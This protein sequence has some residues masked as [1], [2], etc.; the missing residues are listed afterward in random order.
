M[1]ERQ[2]RQK[3]DELLAA[4]ENELAE[5]KQATNN[6]PL[7]NIG[8][9]FSAL[10]NEANL[11]EKEEAWLIFGVRDDPLSVVG[12]NYLRNREEIKALKQQ[13]NSDTSPNMTF[14]DI[15]ELNNH[16]NGRVVMMQIPPAPKG[17]PIAWKGY[18]HAR[19]GESLVPLSTNKSDQIRNQTISTDWSAQIVEDAT[20]DNLDETACLIARDA[21]I[22]KHENRVQ[23]EEVKNW[24]LEELLDRMRIT[25]SGRITRTALLLLG[26]PEAAYKLSPH[27]AEI[28]WNLQQKERDYQHFS[29]PFLLATTD[30]YNKIRNTKIRL[31]SENE[32]IVQEVSKYDQS[33]VLEALHNCIAHQDYTQD[34]RIIVTEYTSKL[35]FENQ[36]NF[37]E[38]N[39]GKLCG[40]NKNSKQIPQNIPCA[41]HDR[42]KY[43]R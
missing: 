22:R 40:G 30:I 35:T 13:I 29:P 7:D 10:A 14:R 9:Y 5:F 43:D 2:L 1:D 37:F 20:L 17:M 27:P 36:G 33:V 31:M 19:A 39:W 4:G 12:T 6:F 38:G 32:L 8:K 25:Q 3:L 15:Y 26:K 18:Y 23:P 21:F 41:S 16:E 28:T 34:S 42:T 11:R 24:S